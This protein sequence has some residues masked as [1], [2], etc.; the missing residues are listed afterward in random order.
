LPDFSSFWK[1]EHA[2]AERRRLLATL[3]EQVWQDD[4]RVVA[5]K[6]QTRLRR[7]LPA[8]RT[9]VGRHAVPGPGAT[10]IKAALKSYAARILIDE[11]HLVTAVG[12]YKTSKNPAG[13]EAALKTCIASVRSLRQKIA[14]QSAGRRQVKAGR[15]K[16]ETSLQAVIVAYQRLDVA[17]GEHTLSPEAAKSEVAN[18]GIAIDKARTALAEGVKLLR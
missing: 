8:R 3:F 9:P 14:A 4:G 1:R 16:L 15:A 5:I 10:G 11:G 2:P 18:A 6:P 13:V 17:F 12:E 7:L